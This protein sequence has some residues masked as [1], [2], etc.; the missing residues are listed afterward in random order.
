IRIPEAYGKACKSSCG[1]ILTV[2]KDFTTKLINPLSGEIINLP[3]INTFPEFIHPL[4]WCIAIQ[5]VVLLMES[6]LVLVIWGTGNKLGFCHIGDDKWMSVEPNRGIHDITFYNGHIYSFDCY[7]TIRACNVN[8]KDPVVMVDVA[9]IA[10]DVYD[11]YVYSAYI[12]GLDDGERK[13]LLLIIKEGGFN[14]GEC[15]DTYKTKSFQVLAFDLES[16]NWSKVKDFGRKT[17]FVGFSSSFWMEDTSGVI[18][19]NC[20]LGLK[21]R[22]AIQYA[23]GPKGHC[24]MRDANASAIWRRCV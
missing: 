5:K 3:E 13:Q 4:N 11:Q 17:L 18:K 7:D 14:D 8:G 20:I 24:V 6:K 1:W 12:V 16:G 10:E 21:M 22:F 23:K 9:K 19:G 2:G 15:P